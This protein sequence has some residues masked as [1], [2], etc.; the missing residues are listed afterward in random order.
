[1]EGQLEPCTDILPTLTS[2]ATYSSTVDQVEE[3]PWFSSFSSVE[4]C[5]AIFSV[6]EAA[7][8]SSPSLLKT[9]APP[10]SCWLS[11]TQETSLS[12]KEDPDQADT[13]GPI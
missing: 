7:A 11:S 4:L 9:S 13:P 12:K 5:F 10:Q 6:I 2:I 3:D 1:M 8:I